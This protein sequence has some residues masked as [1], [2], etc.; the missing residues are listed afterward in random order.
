ME[1]A[2]GWRPCPCR[3]CTHPPLN[4]G[5]YPT[6]PGPQMNRSRPTQ[7]SLPWVSRPA[8][9]RVRRHQAPST[10][11]SANGGRPSCPR[12]RQSRSAAQ[13]RWP[14]PT[15]TM[16]HPRRLWPAVAALPRLGRT[17]QIRT[18]HLFGRRRPGSAA[19]SAAHLP[20]RATADPAPP[21]ASLLTRLTASLLRAR[22]ATA[23]AGCFLCTPGRVAISCAANRQRL[24]CHSPP[25]PPPQRARPRHVK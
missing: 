10:T 4:P 11:P 22:R 23:A 20:E 21:Q 2:P 17:C 13:V 25:S 6:G 14:R 1:R 8:D 12:A 5:H 15:A 16:A 24:G 9:R 7:Q 19:G 18:A 3:S